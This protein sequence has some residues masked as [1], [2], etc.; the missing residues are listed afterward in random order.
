MIRI[1]SLHIEEFR[2]IRELDLA[3]GGR[4]FVVYGP[5]GSGKSGVVDAIDFA[6][7]GSIQRLTGEGTGGVSVLRH[8][9][10][11]HR[12]DDPRSAS[13]SM[14]FTDLVSGQTGTIT[15]TVAQPTSFMLAPDNPALRAAIDDVAAHPELTLSRR[16]I[17]KYVVAKPGE[18]AAQVQSLLKLERQAEFRKLV[19]SVQTKAT[20]TL[21]AAQRETAR[22]ERDFS[23]HLDIPGLQVVDILR[24]INTRRAA[25]GALPLDE[26]TVDSDFLVGVAP[27]GN[28]PAF[29]RTAALREVDAAIAL[30]ADPATL[31]DSH[32]E[33]RSSLEAI[34]TDPDLLGALRNRQIL[35]VGLPL[36]VGDMCPLCETAWPSAEELREHLTDRLARTREAEGARQRLAAAAAAYSNN[37]S[38]LKAQVE[39]VSGGFARFEDA[40]A[41]DEARRW[42]QEL[43]VSIALIRDAE[44][45]LANADALRSEVH[46]PPATMQLALHR[47]RDRLIAEPDQS[48]AVDA[49]TFLAIAQDRWTRVRSARSAQEKATATRDVAFAVHE[50]YRA[51]NDD[52]LTTLYTTVEEDFSRFYRAINSDDERAFRAALISSSGSL[53]LEVDFYQLGMFPPTAYH[54][55]GH[56][57]GMGVCLYLALVRQLLG[58]DFRFAVLDDVVMSVDLNHR[59]NFCDLLK[60]EFPDV[61]FVITTHD[62]VWARQ[63]KASGLIASNAQMARFYGW[64]VDDGP[65]FEQGDVW[66]RIE[67]ALAQD[68]VNGAAHKLRRHLEAATADIAE[69]IGAS[70]PYHSNGRWDFGE[71]FGGVNGR[72]RE[73]LAA[74]SAAATSWNNDEAKAAAQAKKDARASVLPDHQQE[75]WAINVLVHNNDWAQMSAADVRPVVAAS[76]AFLDLYVCGNPDCGGWIKAEGLS[77]TSLRCACGAYNLNLTKRPQSQT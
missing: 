10:H 31:A 64:T 13:V 37:L 16:E 73:L 69:S 34:E 29:N 76:K 33:L 24:V 44:S 45:S 32:F 62:E 49:R 43:A 59:R 46:R 74:A 41:A 23:T 68:D 47:L 9:P 14:T 6:I 67:E 40:A 51:V 72:L 53:D 42:S 50:A 38:T 60:A 54:S 8:G 17:I 63:M 66:A 15:R 20:T 2:G 21:S 27:A 3:L 61:Q 22:V 1:E 30:L 26:V 4:S 48:S 75:A 70:V 11:V 52:A 58:D 36:A 28:E 55:E 77:P 5:N 57:D 18:R 35:E 7:T 19:R 56:Q 65:V 25:L 39:R 12:R 71:L